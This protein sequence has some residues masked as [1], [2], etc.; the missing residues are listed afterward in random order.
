M[1]LINNYKPNDRFACLDFETANGYRNSVCSVGLVIVDN[2]TITEKFYSFVN[3]MTKYFN[4]YCV[5]AHGLTYDDVKNSPTFD[6]IWKDVDNMIGDS[7]IVAHN[8]AF[9]RSC[10]NA[11]GDLFGTKT[12]YKYVCTYKNAKKIFT[13]LDSYKLNVICESYNIPL[14][15][16]HNAL[17]DAEACAK[18]LIKLLEKNKKVYYD[19]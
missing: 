1:K 9:E 19:D 2:L 8:A 11:C 6:V 10:I 4:K 3:P 13:E 16:H 14:K 18:I 17:E 5:D 7:P 12:N 15:N